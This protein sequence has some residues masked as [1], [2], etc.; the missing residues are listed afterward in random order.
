MTSRAAFQEVTS[1]KI[2]PAYAGCQCR[3]MNGEHRVP[4]AQTEL[5][6]PMR[7]MAFVGVKGTA[8]FLQANDHHRTEIIQGNRQD[9]KWCQDHMTT[10]RPNRRM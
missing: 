2:Q 8:S 3:Q 4:L 6:E 1:Y 7:K 9:A 10:W 5:H